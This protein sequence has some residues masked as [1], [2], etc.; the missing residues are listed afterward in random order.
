[1]QSNPITRLCRAV[2]LVASGAALLACSPDSSQSPAQPGP[3]PGQG[4]EAPL[5][6]PG[7]RVTSSVSLS[8][9]DADTLRT[10]HEDRAYLRS[11]TEPGVPLSLNYADPQQ[12]RFAVNRLEL[13]GK[14]PETSPEL[15]RVLDQRRALH[16]KAGYG[17][18]ALPVAKDGDPADRVEMHFLEQI[19]ISNDGTTMQATAASTF[20]G[21]SYYTYL[22][23]IVLDGGAA[24]PP[25]G[26]IGITEE[27][28]GGKNAIAST[29][30]DL[31]LA[32]EPVYYVESYQIDD[33][34][35]GPGDSFVYEVID[36]GRGVVGALNVT[37][38]VDMDGDG[39]I[40]IC[41]SR[42]WNDCDYDLL[43]W[44]QVKMPLAGQVTLL[45]D[46]VFDE[47]KINHYK[48]HGGGGYIKLILTDVGGGC[49]VKQQNSLFIDNM[50]Y[51]WQNTTLSADKRTLTWNMTGANA[52]FFDDGCMQYQ[53]SVKLTMRIQLSVVSTA[54]PN[55]KGGAFMYLSN[56]TTDANYVFDPM[57]MTNSC[58]AEGTMVQ[59]AGGDEAAIESIT[60]DSRVYSPYSTASSSLQV[61]DTAK[62]YEEPP[63]VRIESQS[64]KTLLMTEMHPV[65]VVGKGMVAAK[66][67]REGDRVLTTE[68]PSELI[69]VAREKY[70]GNVYNLKL[71]SETEKQ[72]LGEDQTAFYANGVLVGDGQIQSKYESLALHDQ[73][74]VAERLPAR[75][76]KDYANT[77]GLR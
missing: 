26:N 63:M 61:T 7:H 59:M 74:P 19:V 60:A 44:L 47:T 10:F 77:I 73:G 23:I 50:A 72:S 13:S 34:E 75:W 51:F 41:L 28:D 22:D 25:L 58:L 70:S 68:G 3:Q 76:Q 12:Y 40:K 38:P 57:M 29:V 21:D 53:D 67:L 48:Q 45:S 14:S 56:E 46:Y 36:F 49:D 11:L 20:P 6:D 8:G 62:G 66:D 31:T 5:G 15:F 52:A 71:G 64:G 2:V 55:V 16:I 27:Y 4:S 65:H 39:K 43:G 32:T 30:A 24:G 42:R 1:M 69:R 35:I 37:A 54:N 17:V 33:T 18:G 9:L